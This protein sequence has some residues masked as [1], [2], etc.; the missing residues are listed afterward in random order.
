MALPIFGNLKD[1]KFIK[2]DI[3]KMSIET[4]ISGRGLEKLYKKKISAHQ[5][6]NKEK[7][8][9]NDRKFLKNFKIRLARSLTNIIYTIDP[10]AI[11]FGGGLSNEINFL[12]ELKKMVAKFLKVKH[13]NTIFLKPKHGDSSG[14]RGAA[15]L[16]RKI[17][18]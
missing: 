3:S 4:F 9:L 13:F 11:V 6:F 18:Y 1:S 5:I 16:G 12:T 8:N 15:I 14:V 7:K 2:K 17:I 10:D